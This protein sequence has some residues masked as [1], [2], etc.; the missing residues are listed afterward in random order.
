MIIEGSFYRIIPVDE[1][2]P[3]YDLELLYEI[4]GKNPR[5]EFKSAG[6]GRTFVGTLQAIIKYAVHKRFG[7]DEIVTIQNYV[8]AYRE[9]SAKIIKEL[10][11]TFI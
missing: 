4:G 1:E 9:E 3:F 2:S 10:K 6:Y 11:G 7:E 5:K 8:K